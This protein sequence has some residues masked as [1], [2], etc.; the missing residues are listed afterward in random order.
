MKNSTALISIILACLSSEAAAIIP[1]D[2]TACYPLSYDR[3]AIKKQIKV[4]LLT[5]AAFN[6]VSGE[7]KLLNDTY[8]AELEN[9]KVVST[10][11]Q[12]FKFSYSE[13]DGQLCG[14][15]VKK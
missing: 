13:R 7:E 1:G 12:N 11:F 14:S 5:Y 4:D 9:I 3:A 2:N 15:I 10:E 8:S 6:T